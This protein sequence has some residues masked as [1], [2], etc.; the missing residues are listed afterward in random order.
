MDYTELGKFLQT[1]IQNEIMDN[2]Y[3]TNNEI[4]KISRASTSK[5]GY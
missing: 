5:I 2:I 1:K 4:R 3:M